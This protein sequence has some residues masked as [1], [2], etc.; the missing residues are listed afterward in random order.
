MTNCLTQA[1]LLLK[2]SSLCLMTTATDGHLTLWDLTATLEPFYIID[3]SK[4]AL[5][6]SQ[7]NFPV[8]PVTIACDNRY[9]VHSNSIKTMQVVQLSN[10]VT[11]ILTGG[12]DNSLSV[13]L[14]KTS[15]DAPSLDAHLASLSIPDA[16]AAS[17]TVLTVIDQQLVQSPGS[18]TQTTRLTVASSGNDHRVKVWSIDIDPVDPGTQNVSIKLLIDRYSSVADI[19]AMGLIQCSGTTDSQARE[20]NLLV[21]GVGMEM[22]EITLE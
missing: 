13:S 16:H 10:S 21:C 9:Q 6:H 14:L 19:S 15:P 11:A 3:S 20:S 2:D 5:R 1:H 18:N 12:D 22:L 8:S 17:V 4:L 7:Q